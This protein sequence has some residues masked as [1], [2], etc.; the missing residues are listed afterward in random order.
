MASRKRRHDELGDSIT[1]TDELV[2]LR[3]VRAALSGLLVV[4]E[5]IEKDLW[6]MAANMERQAKLNDAWFAA[7]SKQDPMLAVP[8]TSGATAAAQE[9][10]ANARG[11][12]VPM[13]Q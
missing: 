9:A 11:A 7:F 13:E 8:A 6:R 5:N 10:T 2:M 3:S 12:S 1:P 4:S